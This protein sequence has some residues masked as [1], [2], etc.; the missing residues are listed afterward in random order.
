MA[1]GNV[2]TARGTAESATLAFFFI[3]FQ[4]TTSGNVFAGASI[5]DLSSLSQ[6][7]LSYVDDKTADRPLL[8][9][10]EQERLNSEANMVFFGPWHREKPHHRK[11]LA[12]WGLQKYKNNPG[13]DARGRLRTQNWI[14]EIAQNAHINDYSQQVFPAVTLRNTDFRILP[15]DESHSNHAFPQGAIAFDNLQQSSAPAGTPVLVT[16]TSR[17][18]KWALAETNH[19]IG[20]IKAKDVAEVSADF[21]TSWENGNY[22]TII[23][24]KTPVYDGLKLLY[25]APLGM[26]FPAIG[27]SSSKVRII[28]AQR[29]A[30]GKAALLEATV[31]RGAAAAKPLSF[32]PRNVA[33]LAGELAGG[34]YGWGDLHGKR[35][36]SSTI[37]DLFAS[38]GILLPRNSIDQAGAGRF[39]SLH[40]L[41]LGKK[42]ETI[43][44]K[45]VPWRTLL[46]LPGH[47][48]LYIGLHNGRPLIFHNFWKVGTKGANGQKGRIIV[49][50]TAITTLY[51]GRE[52]PDIDPSRANILYALAGMSLLGEKNQQALTMPQEVAPGPNT[53][54]Q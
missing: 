51:P 43:I 52:L 50:R 3:L 29:G 8:P 1:T 4:L 7:P 18:K 21:I 15:T 10:E 49:G 26:L 54:R 53:N 25:T 27:E 47:I 5:R 48:M 12:S 45:G 6:N 32:T 28:T 41:S 31:P 34:K 40:G 37:R 14:T 13:Y 16:L 23:R 24:D 46:W 19:I 30:D 44:K 22:I 11:E 39:I 36:C 35:D 38:F 33:T 17:D 2:F 42:E 20:W 9:L